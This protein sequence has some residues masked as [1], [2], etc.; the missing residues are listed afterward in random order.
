MVHK[1]NPNKDD[2]MKVVNVDENFCEIGKKVCKLH[3]EG[4]SNSEI[5]SI[6]NEDEDKIEETIRK[7]GKVVTL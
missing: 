1:A 3:L 5:A 2:I 4:F 6:M 7:M